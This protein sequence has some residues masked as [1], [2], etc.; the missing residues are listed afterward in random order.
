MKIPRKDEFKDGL[1]KAEAY[2][3]DDAEIFDI[4]N[5]CVEDLLENVF[6][7]LSLSLCVNQCL[8]N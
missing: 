1:N 2:V 6:D 5:L 3:D 4:V 8:C 7:L